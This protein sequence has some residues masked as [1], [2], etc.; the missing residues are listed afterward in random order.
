MC[1]YICIQKVTDPRKNRNLADEVTVC[2]WGG[3]E[4]EEQSVMTKVTWLNH[5]G[6]QYVANE[7][8]Q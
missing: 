7:G 3:A 4:N 5:R 6:S 2:A 8:A 1:A